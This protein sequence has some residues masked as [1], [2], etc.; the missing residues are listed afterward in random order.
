MGLYGSRFVQIIADLIDV[1]VSFDNVSFVV[2]TTERKAQQRQI[3]TRTC[4]IRFN[5]RVPSYF[6]RL[7]LIVLLI[8]RTKTL[9]KAVE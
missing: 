6:P 7:L 3:N 8:D 4:D 1:V 2:Q 9:F 5:Q